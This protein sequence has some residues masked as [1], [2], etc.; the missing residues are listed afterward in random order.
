MTSEIPLLFT[1]PCICLCD[2]LKLCVCVKV[3]SVSTKA[4]H[5]Y[6]SLT[7][8]E[9]KNEWISFIFNYYQLIHGLIILFMFSFSINE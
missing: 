2:L 7:S 3:L 5:F 1:N 8:V 4:I 9:L 6:L